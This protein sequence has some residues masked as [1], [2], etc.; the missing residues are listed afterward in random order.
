MV[1]DVFR[2]AFHSAT[3]L[4]THDVGIGVVC[5]DSEE[6]RAVGDH[7]HEVEKCADAAE[8]VFADDGGEGLVFGGVELAQINAIAHG[9]EQA[10]KRGTFFEAVEPFLGELEPPAFLFHLYPFFIGTDKI[11]R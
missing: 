1:L 11:M 4:L 6:V 8:G 10:L 5:G 3:E 2:D 7:G 9:A